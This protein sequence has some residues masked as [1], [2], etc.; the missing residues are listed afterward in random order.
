[1]AEQVLSDAHIT[2]K[3]SDVVT[4]GVTHGVGLH[5]PRNPRPLP[6]PRNKTGESLFGGAAAAVVLTCAVD[7]GI[8]EALSGEDVFVVRDVGTNLC[9]HRDE[10]GQHGDPPLSRALADDPNPTVAGEVLTL[11]VQ[12]L[13]PASAG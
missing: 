13:L 1:V 6:E 4:E 2:R 10:F 11:E 12:E 5:P 9:D 8:T 7:A 3:P